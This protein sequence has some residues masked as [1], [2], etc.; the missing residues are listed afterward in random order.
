MTHLRPVETRDYAAIAVPSSFGRPPKLEWL[1][2]ASL[3]IDSEYQREITPRGRANVRR[4][5]AA[6]DW[7][8]FSPV[9]VAP[10]GGGKFAIVD[11]QHRTTAAK[12]CGIDRVPCVVIDVGKAIQAQA[13]KAING[14]VTRMHTIHL[15]HASVAAGDEKALRIADVCRKAGVTIVRNPTQSTLLKVGETVVVTSI[16]RAIERFGEAATVFGL[17]AIVATGGGNPGLLSQTIIWGVIEVLHDHPEWCKD[18]SRLHAALDNI[19]LEEMWRRATSA[20]ARLRG[21]SST[22]QFEGLLVEALEKSFS[23]KLIARASR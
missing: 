3:V 1:S 17:K 11:G 15:H 6:F 7:A 13:F 20:A 23:T 14:N 19:E 12:L 10:A 21:S 2:I 5:A 18:V 9:I 16:G 4:I 8:M 22:D